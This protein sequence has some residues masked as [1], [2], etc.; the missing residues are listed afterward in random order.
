MYMIRGSWDMLHLFCGN[1]D[2]PVEIILERTAHNIIFKCP[3]HSGENPCTTVISQFEF[4]EIL[5]HFSH[6]IVQAEMVGEII[7]LTNS[8]WSTKSKVICTVLEH[9]KNRIDVMLDC[10]HRIVR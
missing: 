10:R 9:R 4:E 7:D 2:T 5:R 3:F 6:Q 8:K 1:H